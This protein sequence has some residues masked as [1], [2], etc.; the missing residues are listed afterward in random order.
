M[1]FGSTTFPLMLNEYWQYINNV[2]EASSQVSLNKGFV[3]TNLK[4]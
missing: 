3:Y 2:F 4:F 1:T